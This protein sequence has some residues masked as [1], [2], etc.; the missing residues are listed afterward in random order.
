LPGLWRGRVDRAVRPGAA[1]LLATWQLAG[2]HVAVVPA[3]RSGRP[4]H[5]AAL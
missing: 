3:R 4:A 2:S 1:A 5:R